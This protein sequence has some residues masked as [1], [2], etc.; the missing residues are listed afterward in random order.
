MGGWDLRRWILIVL[1]VFVAIIAIG[2]GIVAMHWPFTQAAVTTGLQ[3]KFGSR[4]EIKSFR[5]NYFPPMCIAEGVTFRRNTQAGV[6]PIATV[7]RLTIE[8]SYPGFFTTPKRISHVTVE[9]LHVFA[10]P[11]SEKA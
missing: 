11:E 10:S 4:V 2:F 1:G 6:T 5:S 3:Q 8:G 7:A 9:G